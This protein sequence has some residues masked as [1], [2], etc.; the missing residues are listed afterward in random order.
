[1]ATSALLGYNGTLHEPGNRWQLLGNGRRVFNPLLMRFHSPDWLS[2]FARGGLNAYAYC[3]GNP[4]NLFDP[5]GLTPLIIAA[6]AMTKVSQAGRVGAL[7]RRP[8]LKLAQPGQLAPVS[9]WSKPLSVTPSNGIGLSSPLRRG[10]RVESRGRARS[11]SP[12]VSPDPHSSISPQ[13]STGPVRF[14]YQDMD[15]VHMRSL[16]PEVQERI[17]QIRKFGPAG[18]SP[19]PRIANGKV[20]N[21]DRNQLPPPKG[22]AGLHR[23]VVKH[24]SDHHL[25][26][27]R[28]VTESIR[29]RGI[30]RIYYS[31]DHDRVY[32]EVVGWKSYGRDHEWNRPGGW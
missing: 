11:P 18:D 5:S 17:V 30:S 3:T 27:S 28:I 19:D 9:A 22:K 10:A 29:G 26:G 23:Y 20:F 21:N 25:T 24:G 12:A 7:A 32:R 4:V 6:L 1:M 8:L 31:E 14:E 2:P 16:A 15:D 13:N